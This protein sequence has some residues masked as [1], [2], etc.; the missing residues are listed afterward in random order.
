MGKRSV[1]EN[2]TVYQ[3]IREELGLSRQAAADLL[4]FINEDRIIRIENGSRPKPDEITIMAEKYQAPQ[5]L[6]YYCANECE[7]GQEYVPQIE[8]KELPKITLEML[9]VMNRLQKEKD[10]LIEIT[11]DGEITEDELPDFVAFEKQLDDMSAVIASL[12]LWVQTEIGKERIDRE[13]Y[14]RLGR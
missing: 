7:L 14:E 6:N 3:M 8:I 5:L 9:A 10:R 12:K 2:K 1:K 13:T 4:V 11:Y